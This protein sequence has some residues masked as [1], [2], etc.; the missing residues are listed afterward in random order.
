[1][2]ASAASIIAGLGAAVVGAGAALL[3]TLL[4]QR[5]ARR[6]RDRVQAYA[7]AS[8]DASAL[9]DL[10]FSKTVQDLSATAG[11]IVAERTWQ[12]PSASSSPAR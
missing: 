9:V 10:Y 1:V 8:D 12:L 6:Q 5:E 3:G 4:A 11:G 2:D 7:R